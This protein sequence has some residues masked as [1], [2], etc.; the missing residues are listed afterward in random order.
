MIMRIQLSFVLV[1][2]KLPLDIRRAFIS[3]IKMALN[4]YDK[5]LYNKFYSSNYVKPFTFS[6]YL[7][8][9]KFSKNEIS[10]SHNSF[11]VKISVSDYMFGIHLYNALIKQ[12]FNEFPFGK[13]IGIC[14]SVKIFASK[15]VESN[16][17]IIKTLS[18]IVIRDR[19]N[20][21]DK[22]YT[23][24]DESFKDIYKKN[25]NYELNLFGLPSDDSITID[26][27]KANTNVVKT[28][29]INIPCSMGI[30]I[31]SGESQTLN[32][33]YKNG[34]GGRRSEGFGMF[35]ILTEVR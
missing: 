32:F 19:K 17:L 11:S 15:N 25:I 2:K 31:V 7:P 18:P 12:K 6:L 13:T 20:T 26:I 9:A 30:F 33:L 10:L 1:E 16:K 28:F 23:I 22:Y 14:E 21:K 24:N 34:I 4:A 8:N 27:I 5:D 29:N 35:D 3:Y